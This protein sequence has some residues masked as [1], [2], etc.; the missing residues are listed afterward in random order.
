[1]N[2]KEFHEQFGPEWE[3][4][5]YESKACLENMV[6]LFKMPI[7]VGEW[8]T[9]LFG[10][11]IPPPHDPEQLQD[12]EELVG[13]QEVPDEVVQ[14]ASHRRVLI[15]KCGTESRMFD[16]TKNAQLE[17]AALKALTWLWDQGEFPEPLPPKPLGFTLQDLAA[18][19][20]HIPDAL[21]VVGKKMIEEYMERRQMFNVNLMKYRDIQKVLAEQH[22]GSAWAILHSLYLGRI[23]FLE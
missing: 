6:P 23:E 12:W 21:K 7:R 17:T 19:N 5:V 4:L 16:V 1:M 15:V 14:V 8:A 10:V 20:T 2:I 22:A 9:S 3:I 11:Y 18:N 13:K